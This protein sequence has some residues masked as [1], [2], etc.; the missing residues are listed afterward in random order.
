MME[1]V[2]VL[3]AGGMSRRYGSPKAFAELDGKAFFEYG[4]AA[5]AAVCDHVVVITRPELVSRFPAALDVICDSR[6]VEGLGPL[7]GIYT[8]MSERP[9]EHYLVL[10]CDMPF[11]GASETAAL[12]QL[13]EKNKDITAIRAG[14]HNI[15]LF[16]LWR[17]RV[18]EILE[19]DLENRQLRVM[20]LM[21]KVRTEWLDSSVIGNADAFRNINKPDQLKGA[22]EHGSETHTRP[23]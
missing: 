15:P 10:P 5:L 12:L 9:A 4:Y 8:A 21:E 2:G 16:S 18:K 3:L 23:I 14:G 19:Q 7:A 17:A 6:M 1:T 13:A 20:V 22:L 11:I